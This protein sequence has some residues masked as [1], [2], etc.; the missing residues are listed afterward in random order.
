MCVCVCECVTLLQFL[1]LCPPLLIY[2][3]FHV[4]LLKTGVMNKCDFHAWSQHV[5]LLVLPK[6]WSHVREAFD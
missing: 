1:E 5:N 6:A 2:K 4:I 3:C